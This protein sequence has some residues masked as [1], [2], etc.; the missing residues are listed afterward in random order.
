ML[1]EKIELDISRKVTKDYVIKN[2]VL[3][4][5]VS[6]DY[7]QVMT[8]IDNPYLDGLRNLFGKEIYLL[9][10]H[11]DEFMDIVSRIYIKTMEELKLYIL[12]EAITSNASD[13][14][15]EPT[16]R[17]GVI[18]IRVDGKLVVIAKV[19]N[20]ELNTLIRTIK[21]LANMDITEKRVPQ[22]GK[23]V[24]H[25]DNNNFDIRVSS[26]PVRNGE[27]LVLRILREGEFVRNLENINFT[28]L[29]HKK[30]KNLLELNGGIIIVAGPTGSG[31]STTLYAMLNSI[32]STE[33]NITTL[34][35]PIEIE[36]DGI[37]QV[38]LNSNLNFAS[39]LRSILRQDPDCIMVGEI[40]DK[41]TAEIAIR[42]A[43]TGHKVFSTIHTKT[44]GDVFVRLREMGVESFLIND[45]IYG[46]ISQRLIRILCDNCKVQV[47]K[48][49][50]LKENI[51]LYDFRGCIACNGTGYKGRKVIASVVAIDKRLK[52]EVQK[53]N[54]QA[55]EFSN[56]EMITNLLLL[57]KNGEIT[58]L[59]LKKFIKGEG[60]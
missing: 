38:A 25:I 12:H 42:A 30:L 40:R 56:K 45:S 51:D 21:V 8:P 3:P 23:F 7:V 55:S 17:E 43:M 5:S 9:K 26:L 54:Y 57:L 48:S 6:E 29:Q 27:K 33:I 36:I 11:E 50:V 13:I 47:S 22:D 58:V 20:E 59:D 53:E 39:G 4:T 32:K 15:I 10:V 52:E 35:D 49:K 28:R 24:E 14:H 60:I 34:E 37:N 2:K 16:S 1:I 31:K 41:E 18:R 19:L 46:I 44:P